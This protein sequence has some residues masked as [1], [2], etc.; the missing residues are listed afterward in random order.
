MK[1]LLDP[2]VLMPAGFLAYAWYAI[3]LGDGK[4]TAVAIMAVMTCGLDGFA[5]CCWLA[6][7]ENEATKNTSAFLSE[8][9]LK[10]GF[11]IFFFSVFGGLIYAAFYLIPT[12]KS[13]P[14][15]FRVFFQGLILTMAA[16]CQ[17]SSSRS[18]LLENARAP[19]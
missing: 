11:G 19:F 8:L 4:P 1:R 7:D 9:I 18:T 12:D 16:S 15:G 13:V 14:F 2:L 5:L 6:T 17:P 3:G 10:V